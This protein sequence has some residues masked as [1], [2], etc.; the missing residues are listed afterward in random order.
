MSGRKAALFFYTP[1]R[2][3]GEKKQ[4]FF[5]K[6]TKGEGEKITERAGVTINKLKPKPSIEQ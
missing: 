4:K 1:I 6:K 3:G 5:L 2:K